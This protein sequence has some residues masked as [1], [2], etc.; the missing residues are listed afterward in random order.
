MK[1]LKILAMAVATGRIG[2]VYLLGNKLKDWGLSRKASKNAMLAGTQAH[3][4]IDELSPD[5]VITES[6]P[7]SSTKSMKTRELIEA[8]ANAARNA[9]VLDVQVIKTHFFKNKYEEAAALAERFPELTIWVPKMR[10]LWES[11]PR[12][13]VLFEALALACV[14]IDG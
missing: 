7:K 2:Y 12:A 14:V 8:V 9:H 6:V 4:W 5:I 1:Q 3:I 13:T 11:E 10:R